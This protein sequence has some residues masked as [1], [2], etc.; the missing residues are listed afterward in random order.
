MT[1]KQVAFFYFTL[2]TCLLK[3][4]HLNTPIPK[5]SF[6]TTKALASIQAVAPLDKSAEQAF[7][8]MLALRKLKK[9]EF[10]IQEGELCQTVS[11]INEGYI[12][13]FYNVEG[14]ENTIQFFFENSWYTDFDSFLTGNKTVENVQALTDTE[15]LQ[16]QKNDLLTLYQ[17][18]PVFEQV[19][20]VMAENAFLS[21]SRL[22][23]MRANEKP[24]QRY[25]NLLMQRPEIVEKIPQ[26]YVASYLGVKP[27]SLSRIRKRISLG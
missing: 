3:A 1:W 2:V 19:G 8:S 26:K 24:E 5:A 7:V 4:S 10:L 9:K 23:K 17:S 14:T 22:N 25:L 16:I 27:E 15:I 18:H 12:R 11:F 21:V 6:L 13:L 20:R